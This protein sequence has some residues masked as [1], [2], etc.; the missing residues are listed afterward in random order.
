[1]MSKFSTHFLSSVHSNRWFAPAGIGADAVT[2]SHVGITVGWR[3]LRE[4][5]RQQSVGLRI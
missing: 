2:S 1:M 3:H 5:A 4:Q